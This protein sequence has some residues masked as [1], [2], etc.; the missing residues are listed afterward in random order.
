MA[1]EDIGQG[2]AIV[3]IHGQPFNRSMWKYQIDDFSKSHRLII[4]DLRGYGESEVPKN[5]V[6]LDELALDVIHLLEELKI[7][8][9]VFVGLS[10]GGQILF[11]IFRLAPGMVSGLVLAHTDARAET[12]EGYRTRIALSEAILEERMERFIEKRLNLFL[13]EE[14]FKHKPSVVSHLK[15]MMRTT[16][17]MGSAMVQRGRAERRDQTA[18]LS[19]IKAPTL[20]V[21]G[22]ED[23]FTPAEVAEY[24]HQRIL[25]S[26]LYIIKSTGHLSNMEQPLVF[27]NL[28]KDFFEQN[29]V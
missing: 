24:M 6:L 7:E 25:G 13:C 26:K 17:P 18:I 9:A 10:M 16:S 20:I 15:G 22:E 28:L 11:E 5:M 12:E 23:E 4:P 19:A 14:T 8:K 27:N 21:T 29:G 2:P 1:F 3:F